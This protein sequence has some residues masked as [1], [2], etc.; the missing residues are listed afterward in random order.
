ML[1]AFGLRELDPDSPAVVL[2][3]S[4]S[5]ALPKGVPLTHRN[6]MSNVN[7]VLEAFSISKDDVLLGFLP[8]FHSFGLTICTL[9]P[10]MTGLKVAYHPNPNESRKIAK[11][12]CAWGATIAAGTPT[13]LRSILSSGEATQFKTLRA[14]VSGAER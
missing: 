4:G 12:I 11:A 7:G 9:L 8:P 6:I 14:L 5:E 10:L 2:S 13:F 3:T 1:E